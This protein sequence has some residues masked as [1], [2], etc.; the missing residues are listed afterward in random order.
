VEV[1]AHFVFVDHLA[2][3]LADLA[4]T[5]EGGAVDPVGDAGEQPVGR[6]QQVAAF[7]GAF[8]GQVRG[9]GRRLTVPRG[10]RGG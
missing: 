5:G 3:C 7:A 4:R 9:C 10:S 8:G 6:G 1:L 2:H